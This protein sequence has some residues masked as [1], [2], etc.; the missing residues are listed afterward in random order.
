MKS[1]KLIIFSL[2]SVFLISCWEKN[3]KTYYLSDIDNQMIPYKLGDTVSFIDSLGN[4]FVMKVTQD[5]IRLSEMDREDTDRKESRYVTLSTESDKIK[6]SFEIDA[7]CG[8]NYNYIHIT[9]HPII[10]SSI[11]GPRYNKEGQFFTDTVYNKK[12][13]FHNSIEINNKTYN[14]VVDLFII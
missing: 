12:Q 4:S 5:I 10:R 7:N 2:L 3:I 14:D 1:K 6:F 11:F 9:I 8:S 13:Y